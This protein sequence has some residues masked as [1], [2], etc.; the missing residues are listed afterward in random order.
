MT[1]LKLW[2]VYLT[3]CWQTLLSVDTS[4]LGSTYC[5]YTGRVMGLR[6]GGHVLAD[7]WVSCGLRSMRASQRLAAATAI[8]HLWDLMGKGVT[9]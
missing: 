8:L 1:N 9:T 7:W 6:F 4:V 3:G 2:H 5:V